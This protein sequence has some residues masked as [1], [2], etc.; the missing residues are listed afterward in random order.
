[1]QEEGA[2]KPSILF[3]VYRNYVENRPLMA[4][5]S[6]NRKEAYPCYVFW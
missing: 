3:S 6:P 2:L 4:L 1:M 5:K